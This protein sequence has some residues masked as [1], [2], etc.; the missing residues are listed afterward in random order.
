MPVVVLVALIVYAIGVP[1]TTVVVAVDFDRLT[2]GVVAGVFVHAGSPVVQLVGGVHTP[3]V[4]PAGGFGLHTG[5]PVSEHV[6]GGV[7]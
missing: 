3:P 2:L 1:G 7:T 4:Q 6:A 5:L